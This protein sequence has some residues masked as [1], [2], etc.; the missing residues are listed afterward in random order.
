MAERTVTLVFHGYLKKL[1]PNKIKLSG[2]SITEVIN[3][4]CRQFPSLN[5]VPGRDRHC[6][7]IKGFE[8]HLSLMAPIPEGTD[9]VHVYPALVGGK[10]GFF[11]VLVGAV[12]IAAAFYLGGAALAGPVL[13]GETT[14]AGVLFNF[15][16]S[17]V[18]GGLME[19]VSPAPK[20]DRSGSSVNDPEAS[21]YLGATQNTVKIGTRIPLGYG[22]FRAYGHYISFDIDAVNVA[23]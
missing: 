12:L 19:L 15:G 8:T 16:L 9:E 3:G 4:L 6:L 11:K 13:F 10:G 5:P 20:I 7:H 23:V 1:V 17:L 21:K 14:I 2:S 18:L 22:K